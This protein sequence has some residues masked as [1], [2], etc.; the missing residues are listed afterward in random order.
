M[1]RYPLPVISLTFATEPY[2][3]PLCNRIPGNGNTRL[4]IRR[5]DGFGFGVG[6]LRRSA[7]SW[8]HAAHRM[9]PANLSN[10]LLPIRRLTLMCHH[11]LQL[12]HADTQQ[13]NSMYVLCP[14]RLRPEPAVKS[15]SV[16]CN[17][18][19]LSIAHFF[20]HKLSRSMPPDSRTYVSVSGSNYA[21][22]AASAVQKSK[23]RNKLMD[24][25]K[26]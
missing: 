25:K 4:A 2:S 7:F 18:S 19:T 24:E 20:L 3:Q 5:F 23:R 26:L 8:R 21:S 1:Q 9:F 12:P 11:V 14:I 10:L 13:Y 22:N 6:T 16:T 17:S 15:E